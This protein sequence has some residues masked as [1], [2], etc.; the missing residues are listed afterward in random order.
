MGFVWKNNWVAPSDAVKDNRV[1][2]I[3]PVFRELVRSNVAYVL[4]RIET[5]ANAVV[6]VLL[7]RGG[8]TLRCVATQPLA[9]GSDV[10]PETC[11]TIIGGPE[12]IPQ[13]MVEFLRSTFRARQM[14]LLE[15]ALGDGQHLTHI[16]MSHVRVED[17]NGRYKSALTDLL[18]LGSAGYASL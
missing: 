2:G 3:E 17:H 8:A 16:C 11:A 15:V 7:D 5:Y 10:L 1:F 6:G 14:P 9:V 18:R 13:F 4:S 12:G